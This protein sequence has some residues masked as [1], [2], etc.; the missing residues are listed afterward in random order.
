M[1]GFPGTKC[2]INGCNNPVW[3]SKERGL[4]GTHNER[5]KTGRMLE[6]GELVPLTKI[7][8]CASCGV[9]FTATGKA[10]SSKKYCENCRDVE[11]IKKQ[12]K[13]NR[14]HRNT[15]D[16]KDKKA[17]RNIRQRYISRILSGIIKD[18]KNRE[19]YEPIIEMRKSY[20]LEET[21]KK[22]G[23]SRERVRQ[24]VRDYSR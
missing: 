21:G 17:Y 13:Y 15:I 3:P 9:T 20:T 22:F 24:I 10:V 18:L 16:Q 23:I 5:E 6:N 12:Q 1:H 8:R 14:E 4:C 7:I 11:R 2:K 19:R